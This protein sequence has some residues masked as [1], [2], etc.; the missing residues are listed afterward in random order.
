M[1]IP[2]NIPEEFESE[3]L[4]IRAPRVGDGKQLNEAIVESFDEF[5]RWL[6]WAKVCPSVAESEEHCKKSREKFLAKE[7]MQLLLFDKSTG[8]LV[9][10][11]GLHQIDWNVPMF[12][13][14]YWCRTSQIGK[15][16]IAEAVQRVSKFA[17]EVLKANRI[18]IRVDSKNIKSAS[19]PQKLGYTLEGT[20]RHQ[21]RDNLGNLSDTQIYSIIS[22]S[23]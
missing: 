1:A 17:F 2:T 4:L 9:G 20:L 23:Q 7:D 3:R 21:C 19:I 22:K 14:G 10:S 5:V 11:S 16:Y 13:I 15:G 6:P 8:V 12:E 18:E